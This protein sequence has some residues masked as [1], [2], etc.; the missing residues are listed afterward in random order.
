LTEILQKYIQERDKLLKDVDHQIVRKAWFTMSH[1]LMEDDT[2]IVDLGCSDGAMTFAMA[3]L[4]PKLKFTG[5]DK[6]KREITKAKTKYKLPNLSFKVGDA[7][8][9]IFDEAS[10]DGFINSYVLHEIYSGS[11]Y[12]E[13]IV[14]ETLNNQYK[15]LKRGGMIFI[16][17]YARPPPG[18]LVLMEMKD[19]QTGSDELSKMSEV[20]LLLW[21]SEHARPKQ[22]PGCGGFFLEELPPR[23]PETRLF[24]LPYKWAYEFIMRKDDR[25]RWETELPQEYTFFTMSE[26]RTELK[27]LG[28]RLKYT[29]PYWDENIIEK[30]F[31][32]RFRLYSN[33]GH[34]LGPPATCYIAV[35]QKLSE[36]KSLNIVERRP[37]VNE[38]SALK[39]T[40]LRNLKSGD[41]VD[42][43]SRNGSYSELIP[44]R[45][46][47]EGHLKVFLHDGVARGIVNAVPRKG[48]NLDGKRWSGHMI[49]PV[50]ISTQIFMEMGKFDLKNTA[51]FA[52]DYLGLKPEDSAV[53]EHGADYYPSPDYIDE[54]IYTYYLRAKSQKAEIKSKALAAQV[55]RFQA[56]GKIKEF[57]AQQVLDAIAVGLIPS[58]R[59]EMQ[60]LS[61]YQHLG[62]KS[63]NWTQ[64]D[65]ELHTINL[66][67]KLDASE[68]LRALDSDEIVFKD[69]KGSAGQLRC[70]TSAFVE[71][72]QSQG[73]L[74]GLSADNIDFVLSE[75]KTVNTA[76]VLPLAKDAKGD[77]LAGFQM[78]PLPVPQRHEG[79]ATAISA[80]S[81]DLPPDVTNLK[82]AK[83]Y[84]AKKFNVQPSNVV[85][86]GESYFSHAALTPQRIHPFAIAAPNGMA[87]DPDTKFIP[88]RWFMILWSSLSREPHFMTV[89]ARAYRYL[90]EHMRLEAK[91]EVRIMLEEKFKAAQPDWSLPVNYHAP[92]VLNFP[93]ARDFA[94]LSEEDKAK[95][96]GKIYNEYTSK[97]QKQMA[98]LKKQGK[99]SAEKELELSQK[100]I[101]AFE[102]EIEDIISAQNNMPNYA[103]PTPEKY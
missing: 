3:A 23:F 24:R 4:N 7:A 56:K 83:E 74:T 43:V 72:G 87:D 70:V 9:M 85:K 103:M 35:A 31:E 97:V 21:Y 48:S 79:K 32:G 39:I 46:D 40:A 20:E 62:L 77:M 1:M 44:Y 51:L 90:P 27:H 30:K 34:V 49:E 71:E 42:V 66:E 68:L 55:T 54:R 80:P 5:V 29:A 52:R 93:T 94:Q 64:K 91:H 81:F 12:N 63:E 60:I 65:I 69:V 14:R 8:T 36:R 59:L 47:E 38:K 53:L 102:N 101:D 89:L 92:P 18:E 100:L 13:L 61:L 75:E 10:V 16:R 86:M 99:I 57:D 73:A 58:A 98:E 67:E 41:V 45:I 95:L 28:A 84:I 33:E 6:S 26:L 88:V 17:D 76:V 19:V 78:K 2:H 82:Q 25:T 15:M 96:K 37:T 11:R 50:S 22:N